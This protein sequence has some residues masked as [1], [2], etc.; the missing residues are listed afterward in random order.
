MKINLSDEVLAEIGKISV[1][2]CLVEDSLSEIIGAIVTV[3]GRRRELGVVVAA[4]LS[5]GQRI[6]T[7]R[8]LLLLAFAEDHEV[9]VEFSQLQA[10]LSQAEQ[11]RNIVV[12]SVWA[13]NESSSDPHALIRIKATAKPRKGLRRDFE[14]LDLHG[15]QAITRTIGNAYAK[16]A[17]FQLHFQPDS[18]PDEATVADPPSN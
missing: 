10:L 11:Q 15:L 6:T 17:L 13:K 8:A 14:S 18:E 7:L 4:D 2:F 3:G 9:M 16:L 1:L 5:F 12:H